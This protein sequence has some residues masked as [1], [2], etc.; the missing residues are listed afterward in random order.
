MTH[1]ARVLLVLALP[2]LVAGCNRASWSP[3]SGWETYNDPDSPDF[4]V[5]DAETQGSYTP[6]QASDSGD[7]D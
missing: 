6:L 5:Q 3:S 7:D 1:F 4:E 2:V